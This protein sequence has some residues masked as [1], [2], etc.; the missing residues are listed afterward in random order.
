[1]YLICSQVPSSFF[2]PVAIS[3]FTLRRLIFAVH[4]PILRVAGVID[5]VDVRIEGLASGTKPRRA[6]S[7]AAVVTAISRITSAAAS[8]APARAL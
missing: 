3:I 5:P 7:T 8:N 1:M 2:V 6:P 4:T